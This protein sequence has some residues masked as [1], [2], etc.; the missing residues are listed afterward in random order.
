MDME[1]QTC[2]SAMGEA[3]REHKKVRGLERGHGRDLYAKGRCCLIRCATSTL[4]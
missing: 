2:L 3:E 4:H 1:V